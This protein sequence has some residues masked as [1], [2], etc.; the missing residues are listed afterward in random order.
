M[1]ASENAALIRRNWELF[2]EGRGEAVYATWAEDAVWHVL[3]AT[4]FQG[5]YTRDE[6]FTMLATTWAEYV[7]SYAPQLVSCESFGDELVVAFLRNTGETLEGPIDPN[8]G[9]MIYRVLDGRISE[10][11]AVSRGRDATALF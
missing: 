10:G 4:R 3:D 9:L 1:G 2:A 8:G 5:D 6:Y 11:W 7:T